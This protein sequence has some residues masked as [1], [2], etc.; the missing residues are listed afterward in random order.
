ML[1]LQ[2]SVTKKNRTEIQTKAGPGSL[3]EWLDTISN[4]NLYIAIQRPITGMLYV[5]T[6]SHSQQTY[7]PQGSKYLVMGGMH[8]VAPGQARRN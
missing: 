3:F 5:Y 4:R 2:F 8:C 1:F 6:H 7:T